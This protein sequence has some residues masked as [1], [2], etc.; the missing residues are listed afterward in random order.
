MSRY[1]AWGV[2]IDTDGLTDGDVDDF[3]RHL[4]KLEEFAGV[5][6]IGFAV[7]ERLPVFSVNQTRTPGGPTE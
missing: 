3:R 7:T 2:M 5:H 1:M 6:I 4:S